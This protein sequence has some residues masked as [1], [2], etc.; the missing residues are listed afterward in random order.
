MPWPFRRATAE[1]D[2]AGMEFPSPFGATLVGVDFTE[3]ALDGTDFTG[4]AAI[5]CLFPRGFSLPG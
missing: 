4:A 2:R 3:A 5:G 1:E